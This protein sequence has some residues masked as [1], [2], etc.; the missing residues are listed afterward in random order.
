MPRREPIARLLE[1]AL[2]TLQ[3]AK[4]DVADA[5]TAKERSHIIG[6]GATAVLE[7]G[8]LQATLDE[9]EHAGQGVADAR[10]EHTLANLRKNGARRRNAAKAQTAASTAPKAPTETPDEPQQQDSGYISVVDFSAQGR[11]RGLLIGVK[12]AKR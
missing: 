11:T 6:L 5:A 1:R 3:E 2:Q 8:R 4:T 9:L 7:K 12:D 10:R